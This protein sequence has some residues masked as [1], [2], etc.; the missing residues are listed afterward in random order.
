MYDYSKHMLAVGAITL[1]IVLSYRYNGSLSDKDNDKIKY[2]QEYLVD[3]DKKNCP[4]LWIYMPNG[5]QYPYI[6]LCLKSIISNCSDD[7]NIVTIDDN[8]LS[9]IIPDWNI[10]MNT[11]P[12][13]MKTNIRNMAVTRLLYLY[14]GLF[15]PPSFIC[16]QTLIDIYDES[17]KDNKILVG[18]V[19]NKNIMSAY[20]DFSPSLSIIGCEKNNKCISDITHKLET[21]ISDDYT[22]ESA[23]TGYIQKELMNLFKNGCMKIIDANMIGLEDAD[24]YM[25]TIDRLFGSTYIPFHKNIY[26]ICLPNDDI[27]NRTKYQWFA[28]LSIQ[29]ILSS[30]LIIGELFRNN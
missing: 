3:D 12:D 26:G 30:K 18:E 7:F 6:S 22:N 27:I 11:I 13:P 15:V 25:V 23:F 28:K 2:I 1:A 24:G 16:N 20:T 14:G 29:E 8:S 17:V 19:S 10:N 21:L 4:I 5:K 9:T